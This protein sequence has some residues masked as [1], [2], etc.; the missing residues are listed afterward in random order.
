MNHWYR[1]HRHLLALLFL[2]GCAG[3]SRD[4]SA[5]C[6]SSFGADWVVVTNGVDGK[7]IN[8]WKLSNVS[9]VNEPSSDGIWWK[10]TATGHLVHISGWYS[11]VQV[12]GGD[13]ASAGTQ[14]GVD[15][16]RCAGG[17]YRDAVET[18]VSAP[19][20]APEGAPK[21]KTRACPSRYAIVSHN[22]HEIQAIL[23]DVVKEVAIDDKPIAV[24]SAVG[25]EAAARIHEYLASCPGAP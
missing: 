14:L 25:R 7:V 11:R 21:A 5:G 6:A 12:T 4:C 13:F 1:K 19:S 2:P 3:F 24:D 15:I 9:L 23:G 20:V 8:C 16:G 18:A 17:K 10:D 22:G